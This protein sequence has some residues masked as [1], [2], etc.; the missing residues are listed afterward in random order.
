MGFGILTVGYYLTYLF[1]MVWKGEI[2]GI[3]MIIVGCLSVGM[4]LL[5]LSEYEPSFRWALAFDAFMLL[6]AA[7]RLVSFLSASFLWDLP[8]LGG[9]VETAVEYAELIGFIGFGAAL[10]AAVRSLASDVEDTRIVTAAV[11]NLVFLGIYALLSVLTL[12]PLG[13][14]GAFGLAAMLAQLVFHVLMGLMLFSCYMRICDE[15]DKDMPLKKS[16]F[17]WVNKMRE[18]RARREQR[19]ADSVT[20]FAEARLRRKREERERYEAER[21]RRQGSRKGGKK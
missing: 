1:G 12:L 10:L 3:L 16:R 21:E 2:W 11:R 6:P 15:G 20:E 13:Y 4:A 8:F 14:A 7:Y 18:E 17:A 9:A 19:A 5:S